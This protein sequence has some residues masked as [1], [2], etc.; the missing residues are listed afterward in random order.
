MVEFHLGFISNKTIEASVSLGRWS[1]NVR[2]PG[3]AFAVILVTNA[4]LVLASFRV[5]RSAPA[6][7]VL[8][9]GR[10]RF[11]AVRASGP[12]SP[13]RWVLNAVML[14][15]AGGAGCAVVWE[16]S[17]ERCSRRKWCGGRNRISTADRRL[18]WRG[19]PRP[20]ASSLMSKAAGEGARAKIQSQLT[21]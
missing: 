17:F 13:A 16:S 5:G 3:L 10:S 8:L 7:A 12:P 18:V 4:L 6:T 19:R 1:K 21:C 2:S 20:R 9:K 15:L 11:R 14:L